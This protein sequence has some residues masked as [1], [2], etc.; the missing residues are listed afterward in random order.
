M[1]GIDMSKDPCCAKQHAMIP[2]HMENVVVGPAADWR[3][4][5]STSRQG[6]TGGALAEVPNEVPVFDQKNCMYTPHVLAMDVNQ[7][8]KVI[9]SDQTTHNIHPQSQSR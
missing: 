3:M 7:K 2:A 6:L 4:L 1:K 5:F 9:T 8:F